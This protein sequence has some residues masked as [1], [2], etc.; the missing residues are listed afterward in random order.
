MINSRIVA[1]AWG[2]AILAL[3]ACGSAGSG[4]GQAYNERLNDAPALLTQCVIEHGSLPGPFEQTVRQWVSGSGIRIT[5]SN[6][7][8]FLAWFKSH[9]TETV[10]GKSLAEWRVWSATNDALPTAVCGSDASDP[11][12]LHKQIFSQDPTASDPWSK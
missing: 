8:S 7:G 6:A 11:S 3:A 2:G 10:A 5:A 9:D 1:L 12:G 4:S